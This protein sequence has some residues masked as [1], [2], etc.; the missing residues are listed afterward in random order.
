MGPKAEKRG[1]GAS[2]RTLSVRIHEVL[3]GL[4]LVALSNGQSAS[5]KPPAGDLASKKGIV[6]TAMLTARV[7]A[8][9]F[10]FVGDVRAGCWDIPL[11]LPYDPSAASQLPFISPPLGSHLWGNF[12]LQSPIGLRSFGSISSWISS[13]I[14]S[15]E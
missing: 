15:L 10:I 14:S 12:K 7:S 4:S 3:A 6:Q 1:R 13:C 8:Q 9:S 5:L 11:D 2:C